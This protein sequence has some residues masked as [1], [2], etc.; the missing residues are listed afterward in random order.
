MNYL[1]VR[2]CNLVTSAFSNLFLDFSCSKEECKVA[3]CQ[4]QSTNR[5]SM[6]D[7]AKS[8]LQTLQVG[9]ES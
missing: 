7:C 5:E 1:D 3:I 8:E 6:K 2:T 4:G 9:L